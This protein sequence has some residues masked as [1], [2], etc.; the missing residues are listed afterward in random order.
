MNLKTI[1]ALLRT[2]DNL[3]TA[4]PVFIVQQKRRIYGI[5]TAFAGNITFL[6]SSEGFELTDEALATVTKQFNATG[7]TPKNCTRTGYIDNWEFG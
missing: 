2:Q 5:D 4:E 6:D 7:N 3:A 1:G